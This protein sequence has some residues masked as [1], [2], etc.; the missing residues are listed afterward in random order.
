MEAPLGAYKK[1]VAD[2]EPYTVILVFYLFLSN[3]YWIS[4]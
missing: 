2:K 1:R 3:N 4:G